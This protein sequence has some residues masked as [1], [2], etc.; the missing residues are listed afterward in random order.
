M[1]AAFVLFMPLGVFLIRLTSFK[2]VI[3]VHAGI[4]IFAYLAALAAFGL[5]AWMATVTGQWVP[6]NGHPIIGT[7]VIGLLV[8]QPFLG[9]VHHPIYVREHKSTLW[10]YSHIWYGRALILVAVI[11]GGLG[12]QLSGNTV[13]GEIAYG[14]VA[15]VMFLLY[16]AALAVSYLRKD[17]SH[18][19]ET[20]QNIIDGPK[21]EHSDEEQRIAPPANS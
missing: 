3:W 18:K 21:R 8:V 5:G 4:Q 19:G 7:I 20:D 1:G 6:G 15:G 14:V 16:L 13:K 2:G 11:N 9:Y 12:L 10:I 17:N